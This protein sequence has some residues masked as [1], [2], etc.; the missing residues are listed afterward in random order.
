[1]KILLA[2][3]IVCFVWVPE[4]T[5]QTSGADIPFAVTVDGEGYIYITGASMGSGGTRDLVT[6]AYSEKGVVQAHQRYAG[7]AVG[8][9]LPV[10]IEVTG[11]E[12]VVAGSSPAQA[13]GYDVVTVAYA[14]S[15][16]VSVE[17]WIDSKLKF[18]LE[19]NYPNPVTRKGLA[20]IRFTLPVAGRVRLSL[21]DI[22]GKEIDVLV[23]EDKK[24]GRYAVEFRP[25][26]LPEGTYF[27]VLSSSAQTEVKRLMVIR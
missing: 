8:S 12:V 11:G 24:A 1:M 9:A 7:P 19:Q 20:T 22:S 4:A 27:Y 23:N 2:L 5:S 25:G 10:G 6:I 15:T 3:V 21:V 17:E 14:R 26:S 18:Q 16:I 13:T